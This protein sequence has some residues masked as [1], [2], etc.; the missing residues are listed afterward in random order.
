MPAPSGVWPCWSACT[1]SC[2][3]YFLSSERRCGLWSTSPKVNRVD[4]TLM[5]N[6][7]S[8]SSYTGGGSKDMNM[9][10][11]GIGC[12]SI[13]EDV[14]LI[15]FLQLH[16]HNESRS[17]LRVDIVPRP[18]CRPRIRISN[19]KYCI[20]YH[21]TCYEAHDKASHE[22]GEDEEPEFEHVDFVHIMQ[23]RGHVLSDHRR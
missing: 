23:S 6:C 14:S 17:V 11:S 16:Y 5:L 22:Y 12:A 20:S 19:K 1:S 13:G 10:L 2:L 3:M 21:P 15:I 4:F 8:I 7:R 18:L 9:K